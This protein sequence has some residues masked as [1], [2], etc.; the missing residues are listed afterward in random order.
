MFPHTTLDRSRSTDENTVTGLSSKA[1]MLAEHLSEQVQQE[2]QIHAKSR[3]IAEDIDLSPKETGAAMRQLQ[4]KSDRLTVEQWAYTS[5]TT[6]RISKGND[7][8]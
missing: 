7:E 5:G 6:W 2:S 1:Q 4:E 3:F 8:W